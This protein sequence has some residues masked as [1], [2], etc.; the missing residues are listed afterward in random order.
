MTHDN[1]RIPFAPV[2]RKD[3]AVEDEAWIRAMLQAA[4]TGVLASAQQDQPYLTTNLFVFDPSQNVIYLHSG[5]KGRTFQAVQANPQVCFSVSQ[6]GRLLPGESA[7]SM[8]VEYAS[9]VVFGRASILGDPAEAA[10]ALQML[11][12]KYFSHLQPGRDYRTPSPEELD[13][14]AVYRIDIQQWSGKRKQVAPDF[15]GAFEYQR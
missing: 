8:S 11:V 13:T 5:R 6:M 4:A 3:R 9:V 1:A 2:L 15:P 12:D 14:V 10:R 7:A